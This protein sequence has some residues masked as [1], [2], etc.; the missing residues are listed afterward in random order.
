[1]KRYISN[2]GYRVVDFYVEGKRQRMLEHRYLM[3][4]HLGRKLITK[5]VVHHINGDK[6]DNRIENL[7][8][9]TPAEHN[10]HHF[11]GKQR[12][13][14]SRKGIRMPRRTTPPWN[15][16]NG[17]TLQMS[18]TVCGAIVIRRASLMRWRLRHG[19]QVVCSPACRGYLGAQAKHNYH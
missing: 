9:M 8:V 16:G 4:Q 10:R 12:R 14:T 11:K 1:M 17:T 19:H 18:C 7:E 15:K 2:R 13:G 3:E 5:E 6:L